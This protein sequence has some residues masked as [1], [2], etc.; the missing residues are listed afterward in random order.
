M[1]P[2]P[3]VYMLFIRIRP[4]YADTLVT[5]SSKRIDNESNND[6][7]D[8]N[9]VETTYSDD[10]KNDPPK[11]H[12]KIRIFQSLNSNAA[13]VVCRVSNHLIKSSSKNGTD[14]FQV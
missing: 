3:L 5:T 2:Q 7:D 11:I 14:V 9:S 6:F 13:K 8:S 12:T 4:H 10:N 1:Y